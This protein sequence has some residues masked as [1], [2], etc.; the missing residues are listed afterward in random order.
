MLFFPTSLNIAWGQTGQCAALRLLGRYH[1]PSQGE[2]GVGTASHVPIEKVHTRGIEFP[3][4]YRP[5]QGVRVA[6][7]SSR[8]R[9]LTPHPCLLS[10]RGHESLPGTAGDCLGCRRHAGTPGRRLR[11]SARPA[12]GR[13]QLLWSGARPAPSLI[14]AGGAAQGP[15]DICIRAARLPRCPCRCG[16]AAGPETRRV[17]SR[18]AE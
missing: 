9:Q 5:V 1:L 2:W 13:Q 11:W 15:S 16:A 14:P 3:R 18:L 8:P 4:K 7:R 17:S 12:P 10:P 6:P